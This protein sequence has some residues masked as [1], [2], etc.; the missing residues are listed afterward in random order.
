MKKILASLCTI[1]LFSNIVTSAKAEI[2]FLIGTWAEEPLTPFVEAFEKETGIKVNIQTFPFR[3]LLATIEVRGNAQ[4]DDVD[5]IFVDAPLVPSY[6]VRGMIGP[7]DQYFADTSVNAIFAPAGIAAAS[8]NGEMYAPPLNNSGQLTY[9]NKDLLA[10]AGCAEPSMIEAKRVT[11]EEIV[12]CAK[13][14]T[15]E[16]NGIHGFIFDQISRYYQLQAL[17]ESAGGGSGVCEGGLSV[18]GCLT[19]DGWMKAGQFY[20]DIHNTSNISPK[21]VGPDQTHELFGL[22]KIGIF[23]GGS[24]NNGRWADTDL[25][26]GVALHPYFE[27][28]KVVTGCNSWHIGVWN[29]SKQK[30]D[31][32]KL[33]RYLTASPEVAI[34]YVEEHNSL[35]AHNS[36]ILHVAE[37][38]KFNNFPGIVMNLATYESANHCATRGRTPGFLEFEEIVNTSFEDIRNGGDPASV[39]ADAESRIE[40]SMRRYK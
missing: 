21:G 2:N 10:K 37:D 7:M 8:W 22:G 14:I 31:A 23:V 4:A 19:N 32:A 38:P 17:P 25:N 5:V 40:S 28:G 33:V 16:A 27:G 39:L 15:D 34:H 20:Y 6:A 26:Y 1:F 24:W 11:W 35:P 12:D 9:Y 3:D 18:K 29:Y 30:D 13:K 36:A